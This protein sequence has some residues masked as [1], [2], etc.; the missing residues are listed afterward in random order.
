M[1]DLSPHFSRREFTCPCGCGF[2]KVDETL[3]QSLEALRSNLG[4]ELGEEVVIQVHSGCRCPQHNRAVG[5]VP[6][7]LH[8]LGKAADIHVQT[9]TGR[10]VLDLAQVAASAARVSA[11]YRGGI[12]V[13]ERHLH[14]D[15][16]G[17]TARWGKPWRAQSKSAASANGE[18]N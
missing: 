6:T 17:K 15:I 9:R 1:G 11:F 12:G 18:G 3:V 7:S 5:G 8:L 16:R 4:D 2:D 14:L 10:Q 13:Y